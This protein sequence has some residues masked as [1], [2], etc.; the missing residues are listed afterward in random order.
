MHYCILDTSVL[1]DCMRIVKKYR[2]RKWEKGRGL[3]GKE[4][5][6]RFIDDGEMIRVSSDYMPENGSEAF[7]AIRQIL[8]TEWSDA[9]RDI[10][11]GTWF[12]PECGSRN[13]W[14]Y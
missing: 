6:V 1:D 3:N 2:M 13:V 14:K 7:E 10:D 5:V 11:A 9:S 4:Y 8:V 12:C